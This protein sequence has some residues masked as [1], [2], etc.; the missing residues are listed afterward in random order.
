MY[1]I[2]NEKMRRLGLRNDSDLD[3]IKTKEACKMNLQTSIVFSNN[4]SL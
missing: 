2:Y 3:Q 4:S 1:R